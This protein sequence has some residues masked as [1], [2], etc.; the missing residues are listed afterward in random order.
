MDLSLIT[1]SNWQ[2]RKLAIESL[3]SINEAEI[4][5]SLLDMVREHPHDLTPLNAALQLLAL[6]DAPVIPGLI[7]LLHDEDPE[8]QAYAALILGQVR[9]EEQHPQII[10]ALLEILDKSENK[11]NSINLHFNIVEA[12]GRLKAS[13][14]VDRLLQI[15]KEENFFLSFGVIHALGEIGDKRA[16][17][18]LLKLLSD[19][20]LDTAAVNALGK[21][22]DQEAIGPIAAWLGTSNGEPAA[23]SKALGGIIRRY[24]PSEKLQDSHETLI[25]EIAQKLFPI[26]DPPSFEKLLSAVPDDQHFLSTPEETEHLSDLALLLGLYAHRRKIESGETKGEYNI[27]R[28]LEALVRLLKNPNSY[29]TASVSL[30]LIGK[31]ALPWL[32][33]VL[34]LSQVDLEDDPDCIYRREAAL[35]MGYIGDAAAIPYL[36]SALKNDDVEIMM[37]AAESLGKIGGEQAVE[38]LLSNLGHH[39]TAVRKAIVDAL[40]KNHAIQLDPL[41][42][43]LESPDPLVK[44]SAIRLLPGN[45]L[46]KK[47]QDKVVPLLL[48]A[49]GSGN[50]RIRRTAVETLTFFDD[51][52]IPSAIAGALQEGEPELRA[53]AV[54]SLGNLNPEFALP[55][56]YEAL[57]DLDPWVRMY[58]CRTIV[59]F[60]A[61]ESLVF[62][63]PL[64]NDEMAPVRAAAAEA[65]GQLGGET[66]VNPLKK[67]LVDKEPVVQQAAESSLERI[68]REEGRG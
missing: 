29:R 60:K 3:A 4:A 13:E 33:E 8:I 51:P 20:L 26:L 24:L 40:N 68:K 61:E 54:R 35:A 47:E 42:T 52:Q 6:M 27:T 10:S 30:A 16:Q 66:A 18:V 59:K 58:A 5:G 43:L 12:L 64:I 38:A 67:L 62:I 19:N 11:D 56:L 2:N 17:P 7:H 48:E 34:I 45:D 15:L 44:E 41:L 31:E 21:V 50:E 37:A 63:L 32:K 25:N 23:A 65:L 53:A 28:V 55:L 39:S 57:D 36:E 46:A 49:V 14:A 22:G 1:S 9:Y